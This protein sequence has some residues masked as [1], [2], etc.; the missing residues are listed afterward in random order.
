VQ[1]HSAYPQRAKNPLHGL[2]ALLD[3]LARH[4]LDT[5]SDGFDPSTLA[6]TTIDTGNTASNVIPAVP[7]AVLNIRFN[8]HHSGASL[9]DWLK[10]EA[11]ATGE[12]TGI[13]F[14]V[15]VRCLGRAV[16]DRAGGVHR[17]HGRRGG[18]GGMP[19]RP[20]LS[21]TGGTSDARFIRRH[22]EVVEFGLVGRTLHQVDEYA[23]VAHIHKLKA[24][25]RFCGC[26]FSATS[27]DPRKAMTP[28]PGH[29]SRWA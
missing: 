12:A 17:P 15:E 27:P 8:D 3:R 13:D 29:A 14:T 7:R 23:E 18:R 19:I 22:C 20:V 21:T 1:G 24:V 11:A 2:V 25:Y 10:A 5:G 28:Q 6:L 9:T 4:E 26:C 16:P